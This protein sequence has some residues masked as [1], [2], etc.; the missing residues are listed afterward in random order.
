MTSCEDKSDSDEQ[1]QSQ[2]YFWLLDI[3][4][5][6][7]VTTSDGEGGSVKST[8]R[9]IVRGWLEGET[10]DGDFTVDMK[11]YNYMDIEENGAEDAWGYYSGSIYWQT[12]NVPVTKLLLGIVDSENKISYTYGSEDYTLPYFNAESGKYKVESVGDDGTPIEIS[13]TQYFLVAWPESMKIKLGGTS[14]D[15]FNTVE[16]YMNML[17]ATGIFVTDLYITG[18]V[19]QFNSETEMNS[20]ISTHPKAD[21]KDTP[22]QIPF[23]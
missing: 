13:G 4:D 6:A 17:D 20:W 10:P 19:Y 9:F 1:E 18:N 7:K 23:N 8:V 22:E 5:G 12:M 16:I 21:Y 11:M 14:P 3:N 15:V 2:S